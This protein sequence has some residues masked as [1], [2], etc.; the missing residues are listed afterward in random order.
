M[1]EVPAP[2]G[3]AP[4]SAALSL[5]VE[6]GE[7][8]HPAHGRFVI[9]YDP[10]GHSSWGGKF[11][12]VMM[13]QTR[14]DLTMAA[15]PLIKQV[16]WQWFHEALDQAGAGAKKTTGTVTVETSESFGSI[17]RGEE[18]SYLEIRASWTPQTLDLSA[19]LEAWARLALICSGQESG[20]AEVPVISLVPHTAKA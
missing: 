18:I 1:T 20:L 12:I 7:L 13:M 14:T 5:K 19:H 8:D 17:R 4:Y 6:T 11:R 3:I 15:D 10:E 2:R 9:F 16:A